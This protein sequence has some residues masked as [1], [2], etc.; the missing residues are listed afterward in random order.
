MGGQRRPCRWR[1]TPRRR[2][3]NVQ[4]R[5]LLLGMRTPN[6]RAAFQDKVVGGGVGLG[7]AAPGEGQERGL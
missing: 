7:E 6:P 4:S 3:W 2:L 5:G 1:A